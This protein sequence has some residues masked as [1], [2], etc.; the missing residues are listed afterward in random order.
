MACG[1][2][3]QNDDETVPG[4]R[5]REVRADSPIEYHGDL[6]ARVSNHHKFM[7]AGL[8]V[9]LLTIDYATACHEKSQAKSMAMMII[10]KR[11]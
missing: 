4:R 1:L 6:K 3:L 11:I 7:L 2:S 5:C 10:H 8:P 9:N